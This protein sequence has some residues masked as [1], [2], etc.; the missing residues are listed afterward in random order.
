MRISD[1]AGTGV[2]ARYAGM[3]DYMGIRM[4]RTTAVVLCAA[5]LTARPAEA[6]R[7]FVGL[8]SSGVT[9]RSSDLAGFPDV[10]WTDHYT[11]EVEGAAATPEDTLYL[12]NGAFNTDLYRATLD[13]Y[14][15]FVAD[16][17]EDIKSLAFGRDT[18]WGFSNY[19]D[20]KG[21]YSIDIQTGQC[22]L[23]LDTYTGYSFRFFGLGYNP[24]DDMLY[25]YTEYG[26]SGLYSI[27][28]DSGDM[29]K[30]A[31]PIP[32]SNSQGRALAVGD[33]VVYLAATRGDDD[34]PLYAYQLSQGPGGDWEPFTNPYPTYHSSGGAAWLTDTLGIRGETTSPVASGAMHLQ[35]RPNPAGEEVVFSYRLPEGGP[36]TLEIYDTAGRL[37]ALV[38]E[39]H[40]PSGSGEAGWS[41]GLPEGVYTAVLRSAEAMVSCRLVVLP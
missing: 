38:T 33:D 4:G 25:G 30:I 5:F 14:P 21:I 16:L 28:L 26:D 15:E 32:A 12:C 19:A 11:F 27:D 23:K 13:G 8:S 40:M 17:D 36:A 20:T 3:E 39:G 2:F 9:T 35:V 37:R 29:E 1:A 41:C 24:E 10:T 22:A 6:G 34:I 31:D 18:L 7:L